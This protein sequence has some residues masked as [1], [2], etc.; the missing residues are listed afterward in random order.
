M[1]F[2]S[3]QLFYDSSSVGVGSSL[4][5]PATSQPSTVATVH[6][7]DAAD[8][9]HVLDPSAYTVTR[10]AV[11]LL[12]PLP[13]DVRPLEGWRVDTTCGSDVAALDPALVNVIGLLTAHYA[14]LGRDLA[15]SGHMIAE[16]PM[17]FEDALQPFVPEVLT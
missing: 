4:V 2:R 17:G 12:G 14:T 3:H 16:V 1:L 8:V 10:S 15:L 11:Q 5:I 9:E 7:I 6:S 13:T